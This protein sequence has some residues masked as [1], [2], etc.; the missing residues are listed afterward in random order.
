[1]SK[2]RI[3][4][5]TI[6]TMDEDLSII[7]NG[8]IV[9]ENS[10][11]TEVNT[12][13]QSAQPD[14][15]VIEARGKI[16]L[17]G[18]IN[19]H[20]HQRPM[21]GIGGEYD[22]RGW[23]DVYVNGVSNL[24]SEEDAYAGASLGFAEALKAGI[25]TAVADT[26]YP[27][28]EFK[29]A[30]DMGIRARMFA[31]IISDH[32]IIEY[33]ALVK[34]WL[35]KEDDLVRYCI[36]MESAANSSPWAIRESR[37]AADELGLHMHTH[38][39]EGKRNDIDKLVNNG[40][41]GPNLHM[42]HCIQVTSEDIDILAAHGVKVAHCPTSNMKLANGVAKVPEMRSK[43][44]SVAI[45][46]DGLM[47]AIRLDLFEQM[48]IASLIQKGTHRDPKLLLPKDMLSMVTRE[49]AEVIGMEKEIGSLEVGKK[50][51][52]ILINTDRSWFTPLVHDDAYSNL[53]E[54][55]VWAASG[56]DVVTVLVDGKI[57]VQNGVLIDHDEKKLRADVQKIGTRILHEAK[58]DKYARNGGCFS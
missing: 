58:F 18:L 30:E 55:L 14:E 20:M 37:K 9:I 13:S 50:A 34:E 27:Q 6:I 49:A 26:I 28:S 40:F 15:T 19:A 3:K 38:F 45:A 32:E 1:M 35:G 12:S 25:T 22:L 43:G 48:R 5:G 10:R 17:P 47:S 21:R 4:G 42:A 8:S 31:H 41:L 29:A 24:M 44:I 11:I 7:D 33:I 56:E 53:T 36:G 23:H 57:K 52:I 16:I 39:S 51:D 46:T 2:T 54:L